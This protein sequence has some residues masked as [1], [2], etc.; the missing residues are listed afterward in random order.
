MVQPVHVAGDERELTAE[1]EV[2]QLPRAHAESGSGHSGDYAVVVGGVPP[3][4]SMSVLTAA[5]AM[6]PSA[7][8]RSSPVGRPSTPPT[9]APAARPV[10]GGPGAEGART[11]SC[12]AR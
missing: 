2:E 5:S 6:W 4:G 11:A 7:S 12:R 8:C 10:A 9:A 1:D 3:Q